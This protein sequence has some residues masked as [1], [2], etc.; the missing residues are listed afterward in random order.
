MVRLCNDKT[1]GDEI[2]AFVS[3]QSKWSSDDYVPDTKFL[4]PDG[5]KALM[6]DFLGKKPTIFYVSQDWAT[7]RY[8]FDD[9]SVENPDFNY[10]LIVFR[11]YYFPTAINIIKLILICIMSYE[12]IFSKGVIGVALAI[13]IASGISFCLKS[14]LTFYYLF[15]AEKRYGYQIL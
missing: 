6:K 11:K 1:F 15:L 4:N 3:A 2:S 12:L 13:I 14:A 10:V 9:L 8:Y 7:E 5:K